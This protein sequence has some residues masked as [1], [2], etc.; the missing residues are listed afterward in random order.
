MESRRE[1]DLFRQHWQSFLPG[2]LL[3]VP[4]AAIIL[5]VHFVPDETAIHIIPYAVVAV[6]I[7]VVASELGP[8]GLWRR[9]EITYWE[10]YSLAAP[11]IPVAVVC[12]LICF[13]CLYLLPPLTT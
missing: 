5:V 12:I 10:R 4:I 2:W 9:G 1:R 7:Y 11:M 8:L 6:L 13:C 3:P